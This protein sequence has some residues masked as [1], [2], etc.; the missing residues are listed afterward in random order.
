MHLPGQTFMFVLFNGMGVMLQEG[1][2][3]CSMFHVWRYPLNAENPIISGHTQPFPI[4][5]L[6]NYSSPTGCEFNNSR[7]RP[8][9]VAVMLHYPFFLTGFIRSCAL[10][11]QSLHIDVPSR[12][13]TWSLWLRSCGLVFIQ[14]LYYSLSVQRFRPTSTFKFLTIPIKIE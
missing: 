9:F 1:N 7:L 6:K 4:F 3:V 10:F 14:S 8:T 5:C 11:V 12:V 2:S 13:K